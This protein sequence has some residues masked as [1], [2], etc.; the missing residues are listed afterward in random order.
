[1]IELHKDGKPIDT[2]DDYRQLCLHIMHWENGKLL[3]S[4][5]DLRSEW[6]FYVLSPLQIRELMDTLKKQYDES[7]LQEAWHQQLPLIERCE[8]DFKNPKLIMATPDID[9]EGQR[10]D[11]CLKYCKAHDLAV[12]ETEDDGATA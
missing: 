2:F 9:V 6:N 3:K 11:W 7:I 10:K 5:P 8:G 1:M 4:P 12:S